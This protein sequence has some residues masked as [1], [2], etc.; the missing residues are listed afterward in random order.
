MDENQGFSLVEVVIAMLILGIIA[1]ALIPPL[2]QGV[3][4]SSKQSVVAT[5]TRQLNALVEQMREDPSCATLGGVAT[6]K[7]FR[8]GGVVAGNPYDFEITTAPF[9]CASKTLVP[10]Q[11]TATDMSGAAVAT[12]T[13]KVFASG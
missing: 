3:E 9:T 5:A 4:L 13:A 7:K 12:I 6:S 2:W 8:D 10:I 1:I 11:M